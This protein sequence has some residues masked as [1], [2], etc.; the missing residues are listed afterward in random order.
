MTDFSGWVGT[1]GLGGPGLGGW[2]RFELCALTAEGPVV[3]VSGP[4]LMSLAWYPPDRLALGPVTYGGMVVRRGGSSV[5]VVCLDNSGRSEVWHGTSSGFEPVPSA[6]SDNDAVEVLWRLMDPGVTRPALGEIM[7]R[8]LLWAWVDDT[9]NRWR[10]SP[11]RVDAVVSGVRA[12]AR[13]DLDA[14]AS[15][16]E[17]TPE[18]PVTPASIGRLASS[19]GHPS[20]EVSDLTVQRT[21]VDEI[22][23]LHACV[24]TRWSLAADL[25]MRF[26]RIDLAQM[27]MAA[28]TPDV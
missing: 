1:V 8:M 24:P 2:S 22:D 23:Y 27:V 7:G 11:D 26:G 18:V 6:A 10:V 19:V 9:Q 15:L 3:M 12:Y 17:V 21:L 13:S 28:P 16:L 5:H 20:L 25:R 4:D 14:L